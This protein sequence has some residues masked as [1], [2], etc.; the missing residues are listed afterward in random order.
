MA[1]TVKNSL[2]FFL[3]MLRKEHDVEGDALKCA[4]MV[5]AY[6]FDEATHLA[7]DAD[8]WAADTAYSA[9]DTVKPTSENG[10]I[11]KATVGGT[12]DSSEPTFPTTIGDTVV[13]NGVT[14]ECWSVNVSES[15]I[16]SGNGYTAGGQTLTSVSASMNTT[17]DRVEID[18]DNPS[19]T[20]ASGDI[21]TTGS[22]VVWN[23]THGKKTIVEQIQFSATYDTPDGKIFQIN[24]SDG[25]RWFQN[26]TA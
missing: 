3:E 11:Y 2:Q 5:P 9:G 22:A 8:Q 17:D 20:A 10:Y 14:W 4:L 13:D 23:S 16:A 1:A 25:L 26:Q 19:W 12:S 18:A 24:L 6:T 21:A 15:E 7:W